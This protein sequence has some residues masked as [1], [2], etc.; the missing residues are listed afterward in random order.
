M[1]RFALL[2]VLG[3]GLVGCGGSSPAR[4]TVIGGWVVQF[5]ATGGTTTISL[6]D[7]DGLV[8]TWDFGA[9]GSGVVAGTMMFNGASEL[10][11]ARADGSELA[12]AVASATADSI[13]GV[14]HD[15]T[16]NTSLTGYRIQ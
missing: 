13:T 5:G 1:R 4:P 14:A 6:Q 7:K 15:A 2:V 8:G 12:T 3:L 16:G 10:I 11:F 9:A